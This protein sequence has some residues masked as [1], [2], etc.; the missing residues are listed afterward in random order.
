MNCMSNKDDNSSDHELFVTEFPQG[1][2][3]IV[4]YLTRS[5]TFC[6]NGSDETNAQIRNDTRTNQR[7]NNENSF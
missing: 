1:E 2:F 3:G 5:R 6:I 4:D 7:S